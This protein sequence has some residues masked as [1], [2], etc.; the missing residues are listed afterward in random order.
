VIAGIG[1]R[2]MLPDIPQRCGAQERVCQRMEDN[3]GIRIA[4]KALRKRNFHS[5]KDK[6]PSLGESMDVVTETD[7]G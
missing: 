7:A 1:V 6:L 2:K 3:V 5:A 4:L